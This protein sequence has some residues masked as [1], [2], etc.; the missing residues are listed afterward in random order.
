MMALATLSRL[1]RL[2]DLSRFKCRLIGGFWRQHAPTSFAI[3]T[4]TTPEI[5]K[6][7]QDLGRHGAHSF[8]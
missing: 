1:M 8:P 7:A 2:F 4:R 3:Q 6:N 5:L